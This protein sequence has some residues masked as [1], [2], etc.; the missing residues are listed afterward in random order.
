[1][2]RGRSAGRSVRRTY[3]WQ[4]SSM[5]TLGINLAVNTVNSVSMFSFGE[6]QTLVRLRGMIGASLDSGGID[7]RV[8]VAMG[9]IIVSENAAAAG[10][11]SV[12]HP[13]ADGEDD[14]IWHGWLWL[15]SQAEASVSDEALFQ[16]VHVDSKAMRKVRVSEQMVF[17]A[18]VAQV[19]D[20]T[21]TFDLTAGFRLLGMV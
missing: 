15:T 12:P 7:E 5:Q 1:M 2:A 17:V 3:N 16:R 9:L 11:G 10:G 4:A 14:W 6:A 20:Q 18:E 19:T 8:L 13:L 21:G